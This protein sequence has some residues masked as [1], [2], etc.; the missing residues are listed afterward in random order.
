MSTSPA[1]APSKIIIR[2]VNVLTVDAYDRLVP[3]L[4]GC[5]AT[6]DTPEETERLLREA[7]EVH[8]A[9]LREDGIE[10]PQ[11]TS[12]V[13]YLELVAARSITMAYRMQFPH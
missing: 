8:V 4:P 2:R 1:A 11:P 13:R 9:G 6:G 12:V 7:I 10:V 5:V 3:D